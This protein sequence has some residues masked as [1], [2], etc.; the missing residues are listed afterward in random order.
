MRYLRII[1]EGIV[2][3][4][5]LI[6]ASILGLSDEGTE[7][8]VEQE[9][10]G[11]G[12]YTYSPMFPNYFDTSEFVRWLR[13]SMPTVPVMGDF[14]EDGNLD[15]CL[16]T[17]EAIVDESGE[18]NAFISSLLL[19]I[20][21]GEGG[22]NSIRRLADHEALF[23]V[24]TGD[25]NGD[26][27]LDLVM[28]IAVHSDT[29]TE[30]IHTVLGIRYGDGNGEFSSVNLIQ[31]EGDV[32]SAFVADVNGDEND[33]VITFFT[34]SEQASH[35]RT[36]LGDAQGN[37]S[38]SA[39][40]IPSGILGGQYW[41]SAIGDLDEDG[42]PDIVTTGEF[43]D[44]SYLFIGRGDGEGRFTFYPVQAFDFIERFLSLGDLNGDGHLDVSLA[45][46]FDP[47]TEEELSDIY[48]EWGYVPSS[49]EVSIFY[50]DG[51]GH[52]SI[53]QEYEMG[54]RTKFLYLK[55][56]NRDGF[57]DVVTFGERANTVIRLGNQ[58]GLGEPFVY[59][60]ADTSYSPIWTA[61]V[62][63]FN[64]D[65]KEDLGVEYQKPALG[66]RFGN[67]DGGF[68]AGWFSAPLDSHG[69][70]DDSLIFPAVDFDGDGH[71]DLLYYGYDSVGVAYGDGDGHFSV[72]VSSPIEDVRCA[73]SGDFDGDGCLD[74]LLGLR[75]F[76]EDA[77]WLVRG[78]AGRTFKSPLRIPLGVEKGIFGIAAGDLNEDGRLDLIVEYGLRG[79]FVLL[80]DGHG[81]FEPLK[82][83]NLS[84][85]KE[86]TSLTNMRIGDVTGDG[87]LDLIARDVGIGIDPPQ[88]VLWAGDGTGQLVEVEH[89]PPDTSAEGDPDENVPRYLSPGEDLW[90]WHPEY[91]GDL[92]QDGCGDFAAVYA[93]MI[94]VYLGN[95][96]GEEMVLARFAN[97][98]HGEL[99]NS[100]AIPG[101]FNEDGWLDLAITSGSY[102][103]V[104]FNQFGAKAD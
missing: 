7:I 81:G 67:G 33:D 52:L 15:I 62:G 5:L 101:D 36:W 97:Q 16:P 19:C 77:L 29:D 104:L 30:A 21:G 39:I 84:R 56:I 88:W 38:E 86:G 102:I 10:S 92:N 22:V 60:C 25:L 45:H 20:N 70:G 44:T 55:D 95:A 1:V 18:T 31:E 74:I 3:I 68:G 64:G 2:G 6:G 49:D 40:S 66:I 47:M 96:E 59:T 23:N 72:I 12:V 90:V 32:G 63:D 80:A 82:D 85:G 42:L 46:L 93:D 99:T 13:L 9:P 87:H 53:P 14:N 58:T 27:H 73:V 41:L 69:P 78:D 48:E 4:L 51:R 28:P 79:A 89:Y 17:R 50:G 83:I 43:D 24:D 34:I 57:S 76:K 11:G 35:V 75:D 94:V 91:V 26:G 54:V 103:S 61:F 8:W 65:G 71:L 37:L 100:G 98:G